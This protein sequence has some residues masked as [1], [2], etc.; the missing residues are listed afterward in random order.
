MNRAERAPRTRLSVAKA[1]QRSEAISYA[2]A[3]TL[4][5]AVGLNLALITLLLGHFVPGLADHLTPKSAPISVLMSGLLS[6][7]F[8]S[9]LCGALSLANQGEAARTRFVATAISLGL[10]AGFIS[11]AL[12]QTVYNGITGSSDLLNKWVLSGAWMLLGGSLGV[13]ISGFRRSIPAA[14]AAILG[15]GVGAVATLLGVVAFGF[16]TSSTVMKAVLGS[17]I[18]G[19][20]FGVATLVLDR[21]FPL[22]KL[23]VQWNPQKSSILN[24]GPQAIT[25]GGGDDDVFLAGAPPA[26]STIFVEG[27]RICHIENKSGKRTPL[28]DGSRLRIGGLIMVVHASRS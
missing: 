20:L 4:G 1:K 11:G 26:V 14:R 3:G 10:L 28:K 6:A 12:A 7:L 15:L 8:T 27:K 13:V 21:Q 9:G 5:A 18:F 2:V 24:L 25:V 22:A 16:L 23:E 17:I 19:A